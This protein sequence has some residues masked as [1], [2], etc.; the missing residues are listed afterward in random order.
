MRLIIFLLI[1]IIKLVPI[2]GYDVVILGGGPAGLT[3]A[4]YTARAGLS[5]LLI[6]GD[7][8]GG[9]IALSYSVENFPGF[10]EGI[11]GF[12]LS[13][14]VRNQALKFGCEILQDHVESVD[15]SSS[16]FV[17]KLE[18]GKKVTSSS[19]II[20]TG[21]K[22]NWLGLS[23]EK[24]FIG[25]G[26]S[27]CAV[28]DGF[29]FR[30]EEVVVIGGGDAAIE[31]ALFL[32][33]YASKITVVHRRDTLRA[34]P[35]LQKKA[36]DHKKIEFVWNSETLEI[37]DPQK[38]ELTGILVRNIKTDEKIV[39]GCK[40]VFVAIGHSPNTKLFDGQLKLD[41][42]GYIVTSPHTTETNIP[43]V[44]AAG[45][46]ADSRYRQ[47]VTAAGSGCMAA[48]DCYQFLLKEEL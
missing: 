8:P 29:F 10:P 41:E 2:W 18:S 3:A 6:E 20:A 15:F 14:N 40:G 39:I 31:D 45:D 27:S 30:D 4:I 44:F 26:V 25:K 46:V 28:C 32:A 17:F 1:L 36:F 34:S 12:D 43:G 42:K 23:S 13:Q 47:A 7:E 11:N 35:Y 19:T 37:L 21:A 48:I 22:A 9:Q 38:G 33:N 5:T 24:A 16:P